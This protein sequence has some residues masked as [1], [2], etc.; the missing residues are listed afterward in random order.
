MRCLS[1]KFS[2]LE[3]Y[4][5]T[6]FS[7]FRYALLFCV[8]NQANHKIKFWQES[9]SNSGDLHSDGPKF[10]KPRP[11]YLIFFMKWPRL[12]D[13]GFWM[14]RTTTWTSLQ[15][16]IRTYSRDPKTGHSH[17]GNIRKPDV[18]EIRFSNGKK[19]PT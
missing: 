17:T 4:F 3:K 18:F 8:P 5:F 2:L 6:G 11:F 14:V 10:C 16:K 15:S 7:G 9:C 19:W 12:A 13:L 1:I